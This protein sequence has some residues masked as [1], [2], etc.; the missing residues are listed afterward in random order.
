MIK[1]E[2]EIKLA[3]KDASAA[4][5][6]IAKVP[7]RV[8]RERHLEDNFV[9]DTMDATLR[10]RGSLLRVRMV[11]SHGT[12][13]FKDKLQFSDGIRDREEIE[14]DVQSPQSLILIF[15]RL[16]YFMMFRYQKYRTIY[17][18]EGFSIHLCLD[19]TP[20][21]SYFELEGEIQ[22][23]HRLAELMGYSRDR[24]I[25]QSYGALYSAW[26]RERNLEPGNMLFE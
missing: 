25:T 1:R 19:E 12:L 7:F 6:L 13:T 11:G 14:C 17:E 5:E 22:D 26:C 16:G 23:I 4:L 9:L 15:E 21:G 24:Y 2:T 3:V 10:N 8:H 18:M 20:I